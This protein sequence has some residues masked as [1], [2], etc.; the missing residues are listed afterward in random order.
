MDRRVETV[1]TLIENRLDQRLSEKDLASV[2]NLSPWRLCHLFKSEVGVAPLKYL[3]A[4]RMERARDL[5]DTTFFSVKQIMRMVGI[6]D[7]SH[8]AR[9]FKRTYG[10]A[11]IGYRVRSIGRETDSKISPEI[12]KSAKRI[13]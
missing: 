12:A 7:N 5:L 8:F 4:V 2:V 9:D 6:S 11:P 3:R 13:S 1:I 10:L